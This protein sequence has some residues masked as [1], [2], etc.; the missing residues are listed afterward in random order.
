MNFF[1]TLFSRI[2]H[3]DGLKFQKKK[4]RT[5]SWPVT[6]VIN[7]SFL[8]YF[9]ATSQN[10]KNW[11]ICGIKRVHVR[12]IQIKRRWT[13]LMSSS[14]IWIDNMNVFNCIVS[15]KSREY[16]LVRVTKWVLFNL[17]LFVVF[18]RLN[19][20]FYEKYLQKIIHFT[21][22]YFFNQFFQWFS[23]WKVTSNF[24]SERCFFL[25]ILNIF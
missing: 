17:Y 25:I 16:F 18:T 22:F 13:N 11:W 5:S 20:S 23:S 8:L 2:G 10:F 3:F 6:S 24:F 15:E 14:N 21:L 1:C 7:F 9:T 4:L 19:D 12:W